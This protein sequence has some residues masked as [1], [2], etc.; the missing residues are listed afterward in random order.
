MALNHFIIGGV[1][2]GCEPNVKPDHAV[3]VVGYGTENGQD[4]WLVKV[5]IFDSQ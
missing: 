3:A 4:Y 5:K 1:F 2:E